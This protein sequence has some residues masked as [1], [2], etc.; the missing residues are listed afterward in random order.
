MEVEV[1]RE[2]GRQLFYFLFVKERD[3]IKTEEIPQKK[4]RER[5][6]K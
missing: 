1:G 4:E 6:V 3:L 2:R 5:K